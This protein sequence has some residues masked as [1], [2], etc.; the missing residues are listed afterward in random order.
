M[1]EEVGGVELLDEFTVGEEELDRLAVP[2]CEDEAATEALE[3]L[4]SG[5]LEVGTVACPD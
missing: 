5:S 2:V 1:V 4:E 3:L